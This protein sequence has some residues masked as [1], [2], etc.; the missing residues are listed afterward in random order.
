MERNSHAVSVV[1]DDSDV[2]VMLSAMKWWGMWFVAVVAVWL[3]E[4]LALGRD[5]AGAAASALLIA[6]VAALVG[7]AKDRRNRR[8]SP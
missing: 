5:Q 2:R 6:S 4:V 1:L 8:A 3:F 7:F